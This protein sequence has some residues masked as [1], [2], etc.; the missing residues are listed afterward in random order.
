MSNIMFGFGSAPTHLA[1]DRQQIYQTALKALG[2]GEE[3]RA[4]VR[5]QAAPLLQ[6][7]D[8]RLWQVKGLLHRET[9]DLALALEALEEASALLPADPSIAHG[10]ARARLEAGLPSVQAFRAALRGAPGDND[11]LLGL[12]AALAADEGAAAAIA[13]LQELLKRNPGWRAG[14]DALCRLRWQQGERDQFA[15]TLEATLRRYPKDLGLWQL[16]FIIL[17]QGDLNQRLLESVLRGRAAAGD[18][19]IFTANEAVARAELGETGEADRLFDRLKQID[20]PTLRVRWVR[21][22]LRSGRTRE[23]GDLA[24]AMAQRT[25]GLLFWPYVSAAWRLLGHKRWEWLEG[26]ER[27]ARAYD[28]SDRLPPLGALAGR[29]RLLHTSTAQP[30][31]QSV[32]GGT[33]TEGPLLSRIEPEIRALRQALV[34]TVEEHIAQ[35]P[36]LDPSH[37]VLRHRR[38]A[39][40]RI[41]GS[42]SVRLTGSGFHANHIHPQGW[43]SSALYVSLPS[44]EQRGA[45]P[46]G[47]LCLGVPQKELGVELPPVREIEPKPG[48]LVLFPST[49]WHGT[50]PFGAGERLT[51][52]FDV[53]QPR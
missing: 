48:R 45:A 38:D 31:E 39:P 9:G 11:V 50:Y 18:H 51:C 22:L 42:W 21:H 33:Q 27:L 43:F 2:T 4:L 36:P 14:H 52:A 6:W 13:E 26:D 29:L 44:Q 24:H 10:F 15:D 34:Q 53:A 46:A 32:R 30:L 37:P 1:V 19:L 5:L 7:A 3:E 40:V 23:A 41:A 16:L 8:P 12:V 17:S 25:A 49:M 20:E 35:L 28:I 47:W